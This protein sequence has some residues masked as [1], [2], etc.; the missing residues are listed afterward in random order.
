MSLYVVLQG[1][2]LA[3]LVALVFLSALVL[4]SYEQ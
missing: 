3:M 1:V 2:L 4:W